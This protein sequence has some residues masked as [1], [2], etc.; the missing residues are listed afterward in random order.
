MTWIA[1]IRHGRTA[2]NEAHRLQGR[3]DPPLSPAGR[4]LVRRWRV[5]AEFAA[6]G[7]LSSPLC[8]AVETARLLGGEPDSEPRLIEM[9]WGEWQ[10]RRLDELRADPD[11]G[12]A[13]NEARG[14]DFRP[15]GGE[16]Y[17]MVQ[18]RLR[19]FLADCAARG[20]PAIAVSHK[21]V[22]RGLYALATGWRMTG[23]PVD[24]LRDDACH[25]FQ[26]LADGRADVG[27]LNIPLAQ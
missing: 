8:R 15:P 3:A 17:R 26:A 5:P 14:L 4:E 22:I 21:G 11:T 12:I 6:F 20:A 9:D 2:W 19:G 25:L 23:P 13:A 27:R 10:G 18:D 24:R 1:L 7:W 16:S